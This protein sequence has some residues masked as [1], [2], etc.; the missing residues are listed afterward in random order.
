MN[1]RLLLL[2]YLLFW[3]PSL[4]NTV[5]LQSASVYMTTFKWYY[6]IFRNVSVLNF[7]VKIPND[8]ISRVIKMFNIFLKLLSTSSTVYFVFLYGCLQWPVYIYLFYTYVYYMRVLSL[9]RVYSSVQY[10]Y[11]KSIKSRVF[12]FKFNQNIY[13]LYHG[14]VDPG[15]MHHDWVLKS[16]GKSGNLALALRYGFVH[17]L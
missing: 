14:Y 2:I 7:Q 16:H 15:T 3:H 10:K 6:T 5:S 9:N 1:L 11:S 4:K 13:C 12:F 8:G 17:V